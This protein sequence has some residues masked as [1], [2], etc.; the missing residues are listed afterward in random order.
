LCKYKIGS[1][2]WEGGSRTSF[3]ALLT[4]NQKIKKKTKRKDLGNKSPDSETE[5]DESIRG[6]ACTHVTASGSPH[7][8]CFSSYIFFL[9]PDPGGAARL[10]Q[11]VG[12]HEWVEKEVIFS[13]A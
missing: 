7:R 9:N 6:V 11:S 10:Q 8:R 5:E 4:A 1:S 3:F 2:I 12:K 13:L